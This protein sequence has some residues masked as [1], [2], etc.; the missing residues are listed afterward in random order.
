MG[1]GEGGGAALG[2]GRVIGL[3]DRCGTAFGAFGVNRL[4]AR[5]PATSS[6]ESYPVA[7]S[8]PSLVGA[9]DAAIFAS[10]AWV[11]ALLLPIFLSDGGGGGTS[12]SVVSSWPCFR[13][14]NNA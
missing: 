13:G 10:L 7:S 12:N 9:G 8:R 3:N 4:F 11:D 1:P 6:S 14:R 5:V 2:R